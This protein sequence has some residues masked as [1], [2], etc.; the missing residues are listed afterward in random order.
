MKCENAECEFE[1]RPLL[2]LLVLCICY[3]SGMEGGTNVV[4]T[5]T[6]QQQGV[7]IAKDEYKIFH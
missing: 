4:K 7:L 5:C 3:S 6:D 2:I 1:K